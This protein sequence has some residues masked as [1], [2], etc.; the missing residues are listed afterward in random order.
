M[1]GDIV[2]MRDEIISTLGNNSP[3]YLDF[4]PPHRR[5]GQHPQHIND[6][7]VTAEVSFHMD[8]YVALSAT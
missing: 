1:R 3:D 7:M 6:K 8:A 2:A 4:G 5:V